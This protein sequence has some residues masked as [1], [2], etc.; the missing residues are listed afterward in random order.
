MTE[1]TMVNHEKIG[2]NFTDDSGNE[3][4]WNSEEQEHVRKYRYDTDM[5]LW[6][7]INEENW[8]YEPLLELPMP[9]PTA[10][11]GKYGSMRLKFIWRTPCLIESIMLAD[12]TVRHCEELNERVLDLIEKCVEKKKQSEEYK[13][14]ATSGKFLENLQALE[15]FG[16]EAEEEILP[17]TVYAI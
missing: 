9:K 11:M 14:I 6:C 2:Q 17:V 1:L 3:W 12:E 4:V 16:A 7:R 13:K 8:T 15:R 5:K 10:A